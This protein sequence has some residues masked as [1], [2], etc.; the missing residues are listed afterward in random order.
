MILIC[1]KKLL[2]ED[3][4]A[5]G[6]T[7][8]FGDALLGVK[9][10]LIQSAQTQGNGTR[11]MLELSGYDVLWAGS[12]LSALVMARNQTLDLIVIDVALPDIEGLDLC[13]RFR[14]RD[15]TCG[16]PIIMLTGRWYK[17]DPERQ[18]PYGQI[19]YLEKPCTASQINEL[20]AATLQSRS[21]PAALQVQPGLQSGPVTYSGEAPD[22]QRPAELPAL[23]PLLA[24]NSAPTKQA[25]GAGV[26]ASAVM[27]AATGLFN[28]EH[29][30]AVFSK[31]FK[32]CIRFKQ[33][34]SCML[35]YLDGEELGRTADEALVKALMGLVRGTIREVDTAALWNGRELIVL[36]PNTIQSD[37]M[38]AA[39]RIL[40]AVVNHPFTW[41]DA[42]RVTMSIGVAGL[43]DQAIDSEE[44]LI[45]A[46]A[47]S[48]KKARGLMAPRSRG[49]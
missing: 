15:D 42:A 14:K 19:S 39:M 20:I 17:H 23:N 21:A 36:L 33:H 13:R 45:E 47:A 3:Q 1:N 30:E 48:C 8:T 11:R 34:M 5:S 41:P 16:V 9:I 27:D 38:Q 35:I 10:L 6:G 29:F 49:S 43:P 22:E 25:L 4:K 40:E 37:A 2:I 24:Q 28:R 46:A 31:A 44:K 18:M 26:A 12:G 7:K 32:Q